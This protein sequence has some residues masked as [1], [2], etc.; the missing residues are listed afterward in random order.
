MFGKI[1]LGALLMA[2]AVMAGCRNQQPQ[3]RI[4]LADEIRDDVFASNIITR[5]L[6]QTT[7]FILGRGMV[8]TD[9]SRRRRGNGFMEVQVQGYSQASQVLRF[10][11]Q[12]EWLDADG[13]VIDS[14]TNIWRPYSV[15][16]KS[17]WTI[18]GVAPR[19]DA[20]DFRL[21]T[22]NWH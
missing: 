19:D 2:L 14:K 20:V 15:T 3:S 8:V 5:P 7:D 4:G 9:Y 22:R 13:F 16:P 6:L 12:F 17:Q 21:K 10:Q 11:Y 18:S 1:V